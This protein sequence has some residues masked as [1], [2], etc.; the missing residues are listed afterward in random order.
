MQ[1]RR[2]P[3]FF[4]FGVALGACAAPDDFESAGADSAQVGADPTAKTVV[5]PKGNEFQLKATE[6]LSCGNVAPCRVAYATFGDLKVE[7]GKSNAVLWPPWFTGTIA[8]LV[9]LKIPGEFV[10]TKKYFLILVAALANGESSSP[11]DPDQSAK[12]F[13]KITV[14]DMVDSQYQ[15]ATK[16][17]QLPNLHAVAGLSMGGMQAMQWSVDHPDF[18]EKVVSIVGTPKSAPKDLKLWN[19]MIHGLDSSQTFKNRPYEVSKE[20]FMPPIPEVMTPLLSNL[21]SSKYWEE[22]GP[23]AKAKFLAGADKNKFHWDNMHSQLEAMIGHD[24][25]KNAAVHVQAKSLYM[26]S[27]LDQIVDPAPAAAFADA[28]NAKAPRR[29]LTDSSKSH[30]GHL[31]V[32]ECDLET[33]TEAH[34]VRSFIDGT[35]TKEPHPT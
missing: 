21:H 9:D 34:K 3:T 19:T 32:Q 28:I 2:V 4:A 23:D 15:L 35:P 33:R 31:A 29:V 12:S 24:V 22:K 8:D 5:S 6:F 17:L 18:M 10:D 30:C 7:N 26:N 16:T 14:G 13:P 11:S 25:G 27:A 20:G 1:T